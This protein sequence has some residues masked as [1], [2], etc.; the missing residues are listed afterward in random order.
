MMCVSRDLGGYNN[1]YLAPHV[2]KKFDQDGHEFNLRHTAHRLHSRGNLRLEIFQG[3]FCILRARYASGPLLA[4]GRN[5]FQ[6]NLVLI[7]T[8]TSPGSDF[9]D[10]A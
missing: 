4:N 9:F 2:N 10:F 7:A 5:A 3:T 8:V 1:T 6:E